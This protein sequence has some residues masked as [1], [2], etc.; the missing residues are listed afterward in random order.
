MDLA[1]F[2]QTPGTRSKILKIN[3]GNND[4]MESKLDTRIG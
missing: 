3:I 4:A 2:Y 1:F